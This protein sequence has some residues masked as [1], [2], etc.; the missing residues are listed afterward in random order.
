MKVVVVVV[1]CWTFCVVA[2]ISNNRA[3]ILVADVGFALKVFNSL[4]I[5]VK[6]HLEN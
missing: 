6:G 5:E 1:W 2:M 3:G 4:R